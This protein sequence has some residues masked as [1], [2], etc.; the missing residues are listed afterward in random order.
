MVIELTARSYRMWRRH[1]RQGLE[2]IEHLLATDSVSALAG[3]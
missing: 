2:Q 1:A 3:C